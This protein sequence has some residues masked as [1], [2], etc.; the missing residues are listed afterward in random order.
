MIRYGL[1]LW[2]GN[3]HLF[4]EAA[5]RYK[6]GAFDFIEMYFH[7][8]QPLDED[9][10]KVLS[11]IPF[12]VHAPHE[13]DEFIFGETEIAL[14][15][16]A[17]RVADEL[18]ANT[19]VVHPGYEHSIPD[20]ETFERELSKIDEPRVHVENMPGLDTIGGRPFG[21][22]LETLKR[23]R[24][25]KPI[26]FDIE[27]AIKAAAFHKMDYR[28]YIQTGLTALSPAYFHISGGTVS[29]MK[30]Q[31]ND[32]WES[33]FDFAFVKSQLEALPHDA[34]LVFETPKKSK[35]L[36]NDLENMAYFRKAGV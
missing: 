24:A 22:D 15:R 35:D 5:Q 23:I 32:L 3:R 1:K 2:T 31:H 13:L 18:K 14:W 9:G 16:R 27:K 19:I 26:C 10:L 29:E 12:G 4:E 21:H 36:Q 11:G 33:D 8:D 25:L 20:F 7:P 34:R 6:E 30:D 28:E 17:Q